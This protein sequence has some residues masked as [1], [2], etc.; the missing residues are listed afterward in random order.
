MILGLSV[1]LGTS[2]YYLLAFGAV[3]LY[4]ILYH[5]SQVRIPV[6]IWLL[7]LLVAITAFW[8][9]EP[10][11]P[12]I[13]CVAIL[14]AYLGYRTL[15]RYGF[16]YG[17]NI[18]LILSFGWWI[19]QA[20]SDV[21]RPYGLASNASVLGLSA[22]WLAPSPIA[23][24]V[25]GVSMSRTAMIGAVLF[26]TTGRRYLLFT[27]VF[28]VIGIFTILTLDPDRLTIPGIEQSANMR[29]A[30]VTGD[31]LEPLPTD[32]KYVEPVD[33]NWR[34][35]GYGFG[36]FYFQTGHIQPHNIFLRTWYEMGVFS[37]AVFGLLGWI[38][39]SGGRDWRLL[40]VAVATGMFTDEL[41]GSV[42]GVYMILGY[43]IIRESLTVNNAATQVRR[44]VY[45]NCHQTG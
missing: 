42:A 2:V 39:W 17:I 19:V 11:N 26:A 41:I 24:V 23:A 22:M 21:S 30:T 45:G 38:W 14:C 9:V 5:R 40:I 8:S 25:G 18:G 7:A 15:P 13:M 35:Y 36:Q 6:S 34:W 3:L 1:I 28:L 33:V 29:V 31:E 12:L 32:V 4:A 16:Q 37:V 10:G 43:V 20:Y 27:C 44:I